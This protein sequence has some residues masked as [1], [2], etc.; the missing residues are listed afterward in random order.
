MN[1]KLITVAAFSSLSV[2][3]CRYIRR[4]RRIQNKLHVWLVWQKKATGVNWLGSIS[5]VTVCLWN[6]P[7]ELLLIFF[8]KK[9]GILYSCG[10]RLFQASLWMKWWGRPVRNY[11]VTCMEREDHMGN[12]F[13]C[14]S[15][16]YLCGAVI[17]WSFSALF[18][19]LCCSG[20]CGS[21]GVEGGLHTGLWRSLTK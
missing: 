14:C 18:P 9:L 10:Q 2:S 19:W 17:A 21:S 5:V 20:L 7:A 8:K 11:W 13:F 12:I 4:S 6:K 3:V 15:M 16:G 1:E